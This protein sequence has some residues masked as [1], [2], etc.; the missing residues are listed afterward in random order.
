MDCPICGTP[1]GEDAV[2]CVACGASVDA[3]AADEQTIA[4]VAP[5]DTAPPAGGTRW[6]AKR[7]LVLVLIV[8]LVALLVAGGVWLKKR[9]DEKA[10]WE[11]AH[12]RMAVTFTLDAPGYDTSL[13]SKTP[14]HVTGTDLDGNTVDETRFIGS[15]GT[16][17]ELMRGTYTVS[18]LASPLTSDG[19]FYET[20][21]TTFDFVIDESGVHSTPQQLLIEFTEANPLAVT[22]KQV[23]RAYGLALQSGMSTDTANALRA[24]VTSWRAAGLKTKASASSA[25][26]RNACHYKNVYFALDV[27]V[28]W[29][30]NFKMVNSNHYATA[31]S[32]TGGFYRYVFWNNTVGGSWVDD[33][34]AFCVDVTEPNAARE[35]TGNEVGTTK[36]GH[37]VFLSRTDHISDIDFTYIKDSLV[38]Y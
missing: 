11:N 19:S 36:D 27:P 5:A 7:T 24:K 8:I 30:R 13:D 33:T 29:Y 17:L 6:S 9:A 25:T 18:V 31:N 2:Q 35:G 23:D 12:A 16:G 4:P 1:L 20:P 26:I 21:D 10:A 28:S 37:H 34:W 38:L 22:D 32:Q 3:S 15:D 14:L